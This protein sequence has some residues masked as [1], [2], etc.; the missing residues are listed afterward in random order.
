MKKLFGVVAFLL[1]LVLSFTSCEKELVDDKIKVTYDTLSVTLAPKQNPTEVH[2]FGNPNLDQTFPDAVEIL[3][4]AGTYNGEFTTIRAALKFDLESIPEDAV[5]LSAKLT[6][7]SNPTP[8]NGQ[9]GDA[10]SGSDNSLLI[11]RIIKNWEADE[12][13]WADQPESTDEDEIVVPHTSESFE[14]IT[15]LDVTTL[16]ETMWEKGNHGFLIRL[17]TEEAYN[18]RIFCSSKY[19]DETKHPKLELVYEKANG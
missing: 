15:D 8:L 18:F 4:G 3:G 5:I 16:I 9:N 12:I 17:Q 10:N 13:T 6:L 19:P 1:I 2:I 7:F 14:D 11:Q